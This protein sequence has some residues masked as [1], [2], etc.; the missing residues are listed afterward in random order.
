MIREVL[1]DIPVLIFTSDINKLLIA[2]IKEK[3]RLVNL[4]S[5]SRSSLFPSAGEPIL[6]EERVKLDE[7][8]NNQNIGRRPTTIQMEEVFQTKNI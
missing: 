1:L 2:Q 6:I 3:G 7:N 5:E 4:S 8:R